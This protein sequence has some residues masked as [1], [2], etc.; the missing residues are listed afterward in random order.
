MV[1]YRVLD[2][3]D[4]R[5]AGTQYGPFDRTRKARVRV[6]RESVL[7]PPLA[8]VREPT[9]V[10]LN[11]CSAVLLRDA[12][13]EA[14]GRGKRLILIRLPCHFE[15]MNTAI[16]RKSSALRHNANRSL[17]DC[18]YHRRVYPITSR[19]VPTFCRRA[20]HILTCPE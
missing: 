14:R 15:T 7:N 12:Q 17:Q 19:P 3:D 5:T 6:P 13:T 11:K 16:N 10:G 2:Y 8:W 9:Y 1:P 20:E 4:P 18:G